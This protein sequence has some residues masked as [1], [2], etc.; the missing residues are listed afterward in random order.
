MTVYLWNGQGY[1]IYYGTNSILPKLS[2]KQKY[3]KKEI[4][5]QLHWLQVFYHFKILYCLNISTGWSFFG[6]EP[7]NIRA[8]KMEQKGSPANF[9]DQRPG[10]AGSI[11]LEVQLQ[12]KE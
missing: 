11:Q 4:C 1:H 5:S 10:T 12:T 6:T 8:L 7:K 3:F 9:Q 2:P